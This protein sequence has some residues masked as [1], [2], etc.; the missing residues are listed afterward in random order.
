M[1]PVSS[2]ISDPLTTKFSRLICI[3]TLL[4]NAS[5][6]RQFVLNHPSYK[7]DSVVNDEIA[8]DL[9]WKMTKVSTRE[10]QCPEVIPHM[11]SK[12]TLDI[13]AA[14]EQANSELEAKRSLMNQHSW[15]DG[16][17]M[18][19]TGS[20]MC[21]WRMFFYRFEEFDSLEC[22]FF[23]FS[24]CSSSFCFYAAY[25]VSSL[26]LVCM[27]SFC[28]LQILRSPFWIV[29]TWWHALGRKEKESA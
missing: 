14:V 5:W 25:I 6:M 12:T 4:T 7:H 19:F 3:G 24:T 8:Y 17:A 10:E 2:T 27:L 16:F 28:Y 9:L 1:L 18:L 26:S 15:V 11:S 22:L 20:R 21:A 13:S 23:V 29:V